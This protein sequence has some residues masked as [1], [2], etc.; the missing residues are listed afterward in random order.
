MPTATKVDNARWAMRGVQRGARCRVCN[1]GGAGGAGGAPP[2]NPI[3]APACV[4]QECQSTGFCRLLL[5]QTASAWWLLSCVNAVDRIGLCIL[6]CTQTAAQ[7]RVTWHRTHGALAEDCLSN[8]LK[9]AGAAPGSRSNSPAATR[10]ECAATRHECAATR[11]ECAA[12]RHECAAT[13]HECAAQGITV[14]AGRDLVTYN[15][16]GFLGVNI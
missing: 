14:Q 3:P 9:S 4:G 6:C 8:P 11:H 1:A 5:C 7:D 16:R 15:G 10:H 13:R 2:T 12:A